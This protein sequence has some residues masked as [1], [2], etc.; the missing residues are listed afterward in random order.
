MWNCVTVTNGAITVRNHAW[1]RV[2]PLPGVAERQMV[3]TWH[4]RF[5]QTRDT[6]WC[7]VSFHRP[8]RT[9]C[10]AISPS[11]TTRMLFSVFTNIWWLKLLDPSQQRHFANKSIKLLYLLLAS[12][13]KEA[14]ISERTARNWLRKLGY[15]CVKVQ[16][17][18]YHDGHERSD[19]VEAW[20]TFLDQMVSYERWVPAGGIV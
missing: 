4:S 16:K 5:M 8:K 19:V 14:T 9:V 3:L 1:V 7:M 15:S 17:G 6:S 13:G 10:M 18:L 12:W 2:F 11:L 20:K